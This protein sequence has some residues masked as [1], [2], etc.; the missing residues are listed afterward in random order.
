VTLDNALCADN[1]KLGP[2][3]D[4]NFLAFLTDYSLFG[5]AMAFVNPNTVLPILIQ[6]L[7]NS[8]LLIGLSGTIQTLF[9]LFPQL[10]AAN[11]LSGK[12]E[13]KRYLLIPSAIGR[14]VWLLL[15]LA[16]I[17]GAA[18]YPTLMIT[19][20]FAGMA[21]F[22]G[23]DALSAVPWFDILA[24]TIP[25]SRRGRLFGLGQV[26]S[27][28]L[29]VGAGWLIG[30]VLGDAGPP[31]PN[32]FALLFIAAGMIFVVSWF[33][34]A[35]LREP[36]TA[37]KRDDSSEEIPF[38]QQLLRIWKRDEFFRNFMVV[39]LLTGLS[40]L[41][42]PFYVIFAT[43]RLGMNQQVVGPFTSVQ[44][45][46]GMIGGVILGM[47]YE[48]RGGR[49]SIQVGVGIG[50]LAPAWALLLPLLLPAGHPWMAWG[51]NLV[52]VSLGV[53]NATFMQGFFNYILDLATDDERTTYIALAN[54]INGIVLW[55]VAL[56]G[57]AILKL[58]ANSYA[59]L[60][61]VT[62]IGMIL[63]LLF[64]A[65]MIEPRLSPGKSAAN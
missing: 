25:A 36:G 43:D 1:D 2:H 33:V 52:F 45:L 65:R 28:L 38:L 24:R 18:Q 14:P 30:Y 8:P 55:P 12:R 11:Y 56:V 61:A 20:I 3:Y 47:L 57:G 7:T 35:M 31:F 44:V 48:K 10:V 39:R 41:A 29:T 46:G 26:F 60:F 58:T 54:T 16:L 22:W 42:L 63:G 59:T 4:R 51:Y 64:T 40:G 53:S 37:A 15:S 50:L 23:T 32:N 21:I 19:L 6:Q 13:M 27:G 49:L 9:W 34:M 17:L 62:A 5:V